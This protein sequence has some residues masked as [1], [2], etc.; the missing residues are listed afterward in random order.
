MPN[1]FYLHDAPNAVRVIEGLRR[2]RTQLD[3]EI[4]PRSLDNTMRLATWNI[5]TTGFGSCWRSETS[6]SLN[7]ETATFIRPYRF[8]TRFFPSPKN[9]QT[10]PG[11]L[12]D[13]S[14][15]R[16]SAGSRG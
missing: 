4:P 10:R 16:A 1:Y 6:V 14:N 5:K 8:W 9:S 7:L 13:E 15:R 12:W 11:W 2:L 3:A